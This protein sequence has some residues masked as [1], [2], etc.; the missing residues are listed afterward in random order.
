MTDPIELL[1]KN[2]SL[3]QVVRGFE[4]SIL[5]KLMEIHGSKPKTLSILCHMTIQGMHK[6]LKLYGLYKSKSG[7]SSDK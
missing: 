2:Y 3:K 6:K 7:K 1:K 4:K 5:K